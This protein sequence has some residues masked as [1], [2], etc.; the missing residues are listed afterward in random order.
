MKLEGTIKSGRLICDPAVWAIAMREFD[1]QPV[2]LEIEKKRSV[3]SLQANARFWGVLVPLA[4]HFLSQ[5]RDVPL[6]KDQVKFVLC[7]AFLGCEET[8]LGLVPMRTS[9]LDTKQF[10]EF[11]ERIQKWLGENGYTVPSGP[12]VSVEQAI[13]EATA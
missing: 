4:G 5:T 11:C 13:D 7:S 2:V 9:E 12:D 6:S 8:P 10:A 1:G 3:R